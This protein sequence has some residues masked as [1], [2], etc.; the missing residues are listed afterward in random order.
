MADS[1]TLIIENTTPIRA[2]VLGE[3]FTAFAQD[4]HSISRSGVL[5]VTRLEKGSTF[6]EW[7]DH[8]L[9]NA[10]HYA[11]DAVEV[12]KAI[13]NIGRF[14]ETLKSLFTKK[15]AMAR[16]R[17][18]QRR[19][20]RKPGQKSAEALAKIAVENGCRLRFKRT[21]TQKETT[22]EFEL[23]PLDGLVFQ[24]TT[25]REREANRRVQPTAVDV[26][27]DLSGNTFELPQSIFKQLS[28]AR[29]GGK[30]S[31]EIEQIAASMAAALES[32]GMPQL[33]EPIA[34][35]FDTQGS[36]DIA[37]ALR[38]KAPSSPDSVPSGDREPRER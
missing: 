1:I 17:E 31:A 32:A 24:E 30:S 9:S 12:V 38:R 26:V 2:A 34:S 6:I 5:V 27:E 7:T 11:K 35:L 8:I 37:Q 3:L 10:E 18:L 14:A 36:R 20:R 22:E 19:P 21:T 33:I 15:K 28:D 16:G 25:R 29:R 4:Y 23:T 13:K